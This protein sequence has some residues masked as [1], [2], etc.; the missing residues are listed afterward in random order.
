MVVFHSYVNVYQRVTT[1]RHHMEVSYNGGIPIAGWF[2][3]W[4]IH[5]QMDGGDP[6]IL[7]NLRI[8]GV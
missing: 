7:G 2:I 8:A 6:P 5:L 3:S 1:T 4:K